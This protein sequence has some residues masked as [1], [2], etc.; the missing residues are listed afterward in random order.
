M[1]NIEVLKPLNLDNII[2]L[3]FYAYGTSNEGSDIDLFVDS[4]DRIERFDSYNLDGV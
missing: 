2:L 3:G 1:L 4:S